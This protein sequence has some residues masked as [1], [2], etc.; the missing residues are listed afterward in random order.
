MQAHLRI[1]MSPK[2]IE[3]FLVF[4]RA[5]QNSILFKEIYQ[6]NVGFHKEPIIIALVVALGGPTVLE[7]VQVLIKEWGKLKTKKLEVKADLVREK[8]RHFEELMKLKMRIDEDTKYSSIDIK[9]FYEARDLK[10]IQ[11]FLKDKLG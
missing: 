7:T 2:D 1:E 9:D 10:E 5:E 8:N 11:D 6:Q 3:E 4:L